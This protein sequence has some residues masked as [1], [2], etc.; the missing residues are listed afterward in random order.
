MAGE[1]FEIQ[2][3]RYTDVVEAD[4]T[5]DPEKTLELQGL[6]SNLTQGK[7]LLKNEEL[8]LVNKMI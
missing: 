2:E 3:L 6:L 1:L 5:C 7:A 8:K 4:L